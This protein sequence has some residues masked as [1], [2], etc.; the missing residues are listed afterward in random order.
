MDVLNYNIGGSSAAI[1]RDKQKVSTMSIGGVANITSIRGYRDLNLISNMPRYGYSSSKKEFGNE[2]DA[3][4]TLYSIPSKN[5][6]MSHG[7]VKGTLDNA[8]WLGGYIDMM[9]Y[10]DTALSRNGSKTFQ[11]E[12]FISKHIGR[13]GDNIGEKYE[14]TDTN[15]R[16]GMDTDSERS[17]RSKYGIVEYTNKYLEGF[18]GFNMLDGYKV[19]NEEY[20]FDANNSLIDYQSKLLGR[21]RGYGDLYS[22]PEHFSRTLLERHNIVGMKDY[23]TLMGYQDTHAI[24]IKNR[25][26]DNVNAAVENVTKRSAMGDL[27][28]YYDK[29]D[30]FADALAAGDTEVLQDIRYMGL[31]E[32]SNKYREVLLAKRRYASYGIDYSTLDFDEHTASS[33]YFAFLDYGEGLSTVNYQKGSD[34]SILNADQHTINSIKKNAYSEGV[35][36][37]SVDSSSLYRGN[38]V[39]FG[40]K[41]TSPLIQKTSELFNDGTIKSIV[42]R[43]HTDKTTK[44]SEIQSAVHNEY[45]MS[46]GRNLLAKKPSTYNGYDDPYCRVWTVHHQYASMKDRIRPFVEDDTFMKLEDFH[47]SLGENMRPGNA[48]KRLGENSVLM[49]NG[50]LKIA[51]T[52]NSSG[53][54]KDDVKNYMFSIENL[55]WRDTKTTKNLSPEQRGPNGG[56][57]M[58]FPPYGLS[59]TD[60]STVNWNQNDFIGRGEKI[61]TYTNTE[62][63]GN[64]SFILLVDHPSVVN[65]W[66]GIAQI[67][68]GETK[69]KAEEDILRFFAGCGTLD[70][71]L[72]GSNEPNAQTI[73]SGLSQDE[74]F[75]GKNDIVVNYVIFFPNDYT[76]YDNLN[77]IKENLKKYE[78]K[79]GVEW[80]T[81]RDEKLKDEKFYIDANNDNINSSCLLNNFQSED[82]DGKSIRTI[83]GI[84]T[85]GKLC[86]FNTLIDDNDEALKKYKE[87]S[88]EYE[89]K[90]I[91]IKGHASSHGYS[92]IN[93]GYLCD[94]RAAVMSKLIKAHFGCDD[95][96]IIIHQSTD[97]DNPYNGEIQVNDTDK[98]KPDVN[99]V[100]AKIARSAVAQ[101]VFKLKD[102][103]IPSDRQ[104]LTTNNVQL[105][106]NPVTKQTEV[107]VKIGKPTPIN[108]ITRP[109]TSNTANTT[110]NY[111]Y[112]NEYLYFKNLEIN[113]KLNYDKIVD[114]V[115]FFRPAFH[116][117]TPEGFNARLTFLQQCARQGSTE[118]LMEGGSAGNLA[119][120]RAP[121]CVLRIGDFYN[122]KIVIENVN[123]NFDNNGISWDMNPEGIGV[124][125]MFAKVDIAFKFIGGQDLSG[126]IE[127][128][129]N[130]VSY[131]YYANT[132]VYDRHADYNVKSNATTN[133]GGARSNSEEWRF[134][135]MEGVRRQVK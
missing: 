46:R 30:S 81:L 95:S 97:K 40:S 82:C 33:M 19:L 73:E 112:D 92:S 72:T 67:A 104:N 121:Y 61:Y 2:G 45:G 78:Y 43:F 13:V 3:I 25:V 90:F 88:D 123:I 55:A 75:V 62:R 56:R 79:A 27:M 24:L 42:S 131:N 99:S 35:S 107:D 41:G 85:K 53:Q 126:P 132:S 91:D 133:N 39:G 108:F 135:A 110:N 11:N 23:S 64:L 111:A 93:N 68:D 69:V 38:E 86:S 20:N 84:D 44:A 60:F 105:R 29:N 130:A 89:I 32:Y 128:L 115:Q 113:D 124:Q 106:Y 10:R 21:H 117:V 26:W 36:V 8:G 59:F 122:T 94:R 102:S 103:A 51:P 34:G 57:I 47:K 127:R 114:K 9:E 1:A 116:S 12:S 101:V 74:I 48:G 125:P 83:L 96:R 98:N 49:D 65:K 54:Y 119:F 31:A 16:V 15:S 63:S 14:N 58:W 66:R 22:V 50:F 7:G 5:A 129:Q 118:S 76:G 77:E 71:T 28:E 52:H 17:F 120:G 87:M 6:Q 37:S 80:G 18:N 109:I 4:G 70:G 100:E 134:N